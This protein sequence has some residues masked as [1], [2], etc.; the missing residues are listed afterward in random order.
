M[1]SRKHLLA[2]FLAALTLASCNFKDK[3]KP[4]VVIQPELLDSIFSNSF[5]AI[6][7]CPDCAGIETT[8]RIFKDSTISRT[9]YFQGRNELPQTKMGTWKLKDS[10]F[11]AKFDRDKLF[12]KI[13]S[14]NSIL[15]VG[16]DLKEVEGDLAKNYIFKSTKPFSLE[17]HLGLYFMGN[18]MENYN[19]LE[20]I[21][22]KKNQVTINL[23]SYITND[24]IAKCLLKL[25]GKLNK[26]NIIEVQLNEKKDSIQQLMK[27]LFTVREA[28]VFFEN[29][30]KE[31]SSLKCKD[32]LSINFQG[33]YLKRSTSFE[34]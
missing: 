32:S 30:S 29:I 17:D 6:I 13:K 22:N 8:I 10:I 27:I 23:S 9:I 19:K 21:Q 14:G 18:Q 12:Y 34:K 25:D 26:E 33:T 2:I 1:I 24:S 3:D 7:P 31:T 4:P 20:I 15:R 28:H 5:E 11:E 16:S